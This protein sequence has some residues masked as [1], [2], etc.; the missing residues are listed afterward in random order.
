[1]A[2]CA[3]TVTRPDF[4]LQQPIH[5]H[6]AP[7][8]GGDFL[9]RLFLVLCQFE[10]KQPRDAGV[11]QRRGGQRRGLAPLQ[12]VRPF[13]RQSQLHHQQL[14]IDESPPRLF[15]RRFVGRRMNLRQRGANRPERVFVQKVV[16]KNFVHEL[17]VPLHHALHDAPHLRLAEPLGQ[18]I[19]RQNLPGRRLFVGTERRDARMHHL[20]TKPVEL[21]GA[22]KQHARPQRELLLHVR[23]V[24][25]HRSQILIA[26]PN[27]HAE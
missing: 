21:G 14:L 5:R 24:E 13:L 27:Q 23:L 12:P 7:Q 2:Y 6:V 8:V 18:R 1:M 10:R 9:D 20:P 3:T 4:A 15:Q 16:R 11:D 22:G 26:L 17:R 19:H 25:I